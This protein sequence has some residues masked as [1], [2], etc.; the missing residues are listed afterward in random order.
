M[1]NKTFNTKTVVFGAFLVAIAFL[2]GGGFG[3]FTGIPTSI[4]INFGGA[5]QSIGFTAVPLV[6]GSIVLGPMPGLVIA[7]IYD[8]LTYLF[9][10]GGV[11]NPIFT[12]SEIVIGFLPGL[13]YKLIFN[14]V[15]VDK[16]HLKTIS[17]M[18]IAY[19]I[20][21]ILFSSFIG[22]QGSNSQ[23]AVQMISFDGG[24]HIVNG[25]LLACF[26]AVGILSIILVWYFG[27]KKKETGL[28]S[29]DKLYLVTFLGLLLRSLISGWG[30]WLYLGKTIPLIYYWL[31]R[32]ITPL[33]TTPICAYA[34][35][36]L[37]YILK[38][39]AK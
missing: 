10:T 2:L 5:Q 37:S 24:F 38:K 29:Y 32:F 34:I 17:I 39:Y 16:P 28:F 27:N 6:I 13:I 8:T 9:I 12:I 31:P 30:L 3:R 11:W 1:K 23:K 7:A 35:S 21:V 18:L 19:I 20:G 22:E 36:K 14:K 33:F 26:I 15:K 4:K 25:V